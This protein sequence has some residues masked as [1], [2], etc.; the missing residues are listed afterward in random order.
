[1]NFKKQRK[2]ERN[3]EKIKDNGIYLKYGLKKP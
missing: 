2:T 1:M 3:R